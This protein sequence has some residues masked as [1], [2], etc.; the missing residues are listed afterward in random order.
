MAIN[1]I[2]ETTPAAIAQVKSLI[3]TA[4]FGALAVLPPQT[5][6]PNVSRIALGTTHEGHPMT[7]VSDLSTHTKALRENPNCGLL[8]GEP[9]DKGDPLTYP[10]VSLQARA[11]FVRRQDALQSGLRD[12]Y[13]ATHPK[14]KLYIDFTDFNFMTFDILR[15]DLNGGFGKAF[16]LTADDLA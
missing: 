10:R 9:E 7:L 6:A 11:V 5:H 15:A 3:E 12:H 14:S 13:L 1:P 2:H 16:R 4:R 8:I